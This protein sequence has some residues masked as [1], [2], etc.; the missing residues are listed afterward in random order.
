MT[1]MNL[2]APRGGFLA[3]HPVLIDALIGLAYVL[4][5][6]PGLVHSLAIGSVPVWAGVL[7]TVATIGSGAALFFRRRA[8]I[9]VLAIVFVLAMVKTFACGLVDP[10]ALTLAGY[11]AGAHLP[12]RKGGVTVSVSIAAVVVVVL[13]A[14]P[15]APEAISA[16]VLLILF[17]VPLIPACLLG[18]LMR[19]RS[20]LRDSEYRRL[21]HE[22]HERE[23]AAELRAVRERTALSREM[24]DV[25]GHSLTAIINISD[26]ALR[27]SGTH[28]EVSEESLRQV[29]Q[30]ARDAL[31]ETRA[32]LGTL[33]PDGEVAPR[34][35]AQALAVDLDP[36]PISDQTLPESGLRDLLRTAETTGL[37]TTLT[38]HGTRV[39]LEE[40]IRTATFR[41]VQEAITNTMRHAT[42]ATRVD[43][44]LT[45]GAS[46]IAVQ[47]HDDGTASDAHSLAGQGLTGVTERA[48]QLGGTAR[49]GPAP[50]GG[51]HLTATIPLTSAR[52]GAR[53]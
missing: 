30:V 33:R 26:G 47:V 11:A 42:G 50:A 34:N 9:T 45:Y 7:G 6:A 15:L 16:G 19:T 21:T 3:A 37:S 36:P 48:T 18:L 12:L 2:T 20:N 46:D 27:V 23:Q 28:A 40:D 43:V 14:A 10:V 22:A 24:H 44:T 4:V 5:L 38:V 13:L 35:P 17:L 41:I 25:V 51:W 1:S 49:Y 32:I 52:S 31:A 8:T 39:P 29:N 53:A